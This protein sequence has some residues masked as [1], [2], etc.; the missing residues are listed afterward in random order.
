MHIHF[1]DSELEGF[2]RSLE[3]PVIAKVLRAIDLLEMF[4]HQI[5]PPHSK[6]VEIRLF[7]LRIRGRQEVRIFYTFHKNEA[8]L[9]YGFV[10]KSKR[11]PKREIQTAVQKLKA[12][13][14]V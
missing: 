6:K 10:K 2:I 11:I 8:V 5:S 12:L 7:E 14:S 1:L 3:K 4:G 13:D 9:L